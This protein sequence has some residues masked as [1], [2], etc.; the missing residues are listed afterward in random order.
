MIT[1]IDKISPQEI[2]KKSED[3]ILKAGGEILDWL[4]V[5]KVT[6]TKS[7]KE[8]MDRALVLNAMYQLYLKA[9]KNHIMNWMIE[10]NLLDKLTPNESRILCSIEQNLAEDE[11]IEL[12]W[13]L[14]AL[15]AIAW[16]TNLTASLSFSE[17]IGSELAG[18]SPNLQRNDDG[19]K[20]YSK[21][22]LRP[23]KELHA[24]LDLYYRLHW[25]INHA[26][27]EGRSIGNISPAAIIERRRALE[28]ICNSNIEWDEVDLSL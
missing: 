28:W 12:Y 7:Q 24:M 19:H 22:K 5:I 9:P 16:A 25:W 18:L 17:P 4:P 21:M 13:S 3:I 1:S 11:K 27:Q 14:E 6:E 10:N 20:Y 26:I 8:V 23:V 2:K 15:W